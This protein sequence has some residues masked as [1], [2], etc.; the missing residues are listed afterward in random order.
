MTT[1][2]KHLYKFQENLF[3]IF[4]FFTYSIIFL[5]AF[6]LSIL[7]DNFLLNLDYYVRIYICLF[8]LFRFNPLRSNIK[9]TNLDRKI[10]FSAG[11]I[12]LTTTTLNKYIQEIRNIFTNT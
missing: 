8:L 2:K 3:D 12:I 7:P 5:S 4:I 10:T 11:L 6:G 1:I 9:F